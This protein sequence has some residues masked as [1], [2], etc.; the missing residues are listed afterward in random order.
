TVEQPHEGNRNLA[1]TVEYHT[2]LIDLA[3]WVQLRFHR[4]HLF[5][6]T[7]ERYTVADLKYHICGGN[8]VRGVGLG[9]GCHPNLLGQRGVFEGFSSIFAWTCDPELLHL[10]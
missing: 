7:E 3:R 2:C 4:H 6:Q 5:G 8:L 1:S 9:H 10:N